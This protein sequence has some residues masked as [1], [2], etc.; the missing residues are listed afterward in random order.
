MPAELD[1]PRAQRWLQAFIVS[2]ADTD[3]EALRSEAVTAEYRGDVSHVVTPSQTLTSAERAGVYRGMYLQR[4]QEA[5]ESDYPVVRDWL[6]ELQFV[7]LATGYVREYPSRSYT[8]NRLGDHLPAYIESLPEFEHRSLLLDLAR[9]ELAVTEAFDAEETPPLNE[10]AIAAV[11]EDAWETARLEPIAAMRRLTL[12]HPVDR[13]KEAD[14]D[15]LDYPAPATETTHIAVYRREYRVFWMKLSEPAFGL[16]NA[17]AESAP[18]GEALEQS[19]L[20]GGAE[21]EAL[22]GWFQ[23]W[24]RAGLFRSVALASA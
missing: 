6:G 15:G 23:D 3:E 24:L 18:L 8:L 9:F 14:R 19:M 2:P 7:R 10:E 22:S 5:L 17:L 13:F 11:P 20:S 21:E 16:L 4:L 12:D 1:L